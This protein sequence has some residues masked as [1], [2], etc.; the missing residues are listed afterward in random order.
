MS[1]YKCERCKTEESMFWWPFA[2]SDRN[3]IFLCDDCA[4]NLIQWL[5][6]PP[7]EERK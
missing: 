1:F 2:L 7:K 5:D 4:F 6:T 3:T